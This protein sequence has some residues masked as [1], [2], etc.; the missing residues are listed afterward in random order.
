M[1]D[2]YIPIIFNGGSYGSFLMFCLTNLNTKEFKNPL[3]GATGNSHKFL[4]NYV[5]LDNND[6]N[7][8]K[9]IDNK[10][11]KYH[12]KTFKTQSLKEE[13]DRIVAATNKSILIYPSVDHYLLVINNQFEKVYNNT[14]SDKWHNDN[15]E[16]EI[17][18]KN[19]YDGWNIDPSLSINEID[20]WVVR[21]FLS[22]YYFEAFNGEYEWNLLET[23][24]NDNL[25][26]VTT[27]DLLYD[28]ENC[29]KKCASYCGID[30]ITNFDELIELQK[31]Q[32]KLQKHKHKDTIVKQVID[33][34]LNDKQLKIP[35]LSLIDEAYIQYVLRKNGFELCCEGLNKF[36][37]DI[38]TLKEKTSKT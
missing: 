12:P 23:Y 6:W 22:Y 36:P 26:I 9:K 18:Y 8:V 7:I 37:T 34:F 11:I 28:F 17:F 21:E 29:I 27:Q 25:L 14:I 15:D 10:W 4:F 5:T 35:E 32:L 16:R 20:K 1:I 19:L 3:C 38:N 2:N 13:I 30:T 31:E 24:T 33:C